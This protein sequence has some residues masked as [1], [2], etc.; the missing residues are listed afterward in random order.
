MSPFCLLCLLAVSVSPSCVVDYNDT[1]EIYLARGEKVEADAAP[2]FS[3]SLGLAIE[4]LIEGV[5]IASLWK[6]NNPIVAAPRFQQEQA[7]H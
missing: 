2:V 5:S 1:R 4:P 7:V 6:I 3:P